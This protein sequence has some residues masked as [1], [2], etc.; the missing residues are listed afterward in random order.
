METITRADDRKEPT[1]AR[2]ARVKELL[3]TVHDDLSHWEWDFQRMRANR[4]YA[5][6]LQWQGMTRKDLVKEDR[7]YVENVTFRHL[8]SRTAAIYARNPRFTWRQSK[9]LHHV[10][11]DGSPEMVQMAT[12]QMTGTP[13][14]VDPMTG[15]VT[16]AVPPQPS[17]LAMAI[18]QEATQYAQDQSNFKKMGETLAILYEYFLREQIFNIKH[19][20]KRTVLQ[21]GTC[22]LGYIKQT[23]Q[24]TLQ[25][26]PEVEQGLADT[27]S[28][29]D[30]ITRLSQELA[31]GEIDPNEAEA[32]RLKTLM[33]DMEGREKMLLREGLVFN[34]PDPLNI[35]PS[36]DMI[37]LPGFFGCPHV[38]EQYFLTEA[39]V[40]ETYGVDLGGRAQAYRSS[41]PGNKMGE[42]LDFAKTTTWEA[43]D[44]ARVFE[45]YHKGDGLVYT[46]CEGHD[47]YLREP[48][49]P[50][51][52][53]ERFWPWF[54]YAP[55]AM[56][57]PENPMPPSEVELIQPMQNEINAAGDG[58]RDHRW[59]ARP[60][61]VVPGFLSEENGKR[62][63][64]RA[65]HGV[66]ILEGM[67]PDASVEQVL[68]AF[69]TAPIDPNLYNTGPAFEGML[70]T[71]GTQQ[72]NLGPTSDATATEATIAQS[73]RQS[74]D[75]SAID[76][77]DDLLTEMARAGGQIL[78]LN[79]DAETVKKIVGPGAMW[80]ETTREEVAQELYLEVEAGSSGKKNQAHEVQVRQM[81]YPFLLQTPNL[82]PDKFAKD[83]LS[84]LDDR[85]QYEDWQKPG[86]PSIVAMNG[87]A[88]AQAN[89]GPAADPAADPA[90]QGPAGA[91]NA[92][93]Q[94]SPG[95]TG[96]QSPAPFTPT[97]Q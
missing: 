95:Q 1:D 34:F 94:A 11:W 85:I 66:V 48:E 86:T 33:K 80:P 51:P 93:Q 18:I 59:A 69:P 40:R 56:D 17:E 76:E 54:V 19:M 81:M 60:G 45:I 83:M 44:C 27:K 36:K 65:A 2:A 70:R 75:D 14:S 62:I 42:R 20:M 73:S 71:V 90:A 31:F 25:N 58:L 28:Q 92:P 72:A 5:R 4:R 7:P 10:L 3:D 15:V 49:P 79:V 13:E 21:S 91:S 53:T 74:T 6:G 78:L 57:D 12:Q 39:K 30:T 38:T 52:W 67:P 35:I 61:H 9:R 88:Q 46:I 96:P 43:G 8:K 82:D 97:V 24:R 50:F 63:Q 16:P 77:L 47:D 84:V 32:D 29:L 68:Q 55:N 87:M 64:G 37:F 22:G 89:A 26:T 23:F 41:D